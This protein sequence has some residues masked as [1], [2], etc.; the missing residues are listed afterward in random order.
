[1]TP[2]DADTA[3]DYLLMYFLYFKHSAAKGMSCVSQ[4]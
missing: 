3:N 4:G 1:M 2:F